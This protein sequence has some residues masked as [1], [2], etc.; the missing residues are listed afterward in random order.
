MKKLLLLPLCIVAM[1]MA[2]CTSVEDNPTP[3]PIVPDEPQPT[4]KADY[5]ILMYGMG[6]GQLIGGGELDQCI[7]CM[8]INQMFE[9]KKNAGD[10]INVVVNYKFSPVLND[11]FYA[12]HNLEG[13][14]EIDNEK[15]SM[16]EFAGKTYRF[17]IEDD[18]TMFDTFVD[19]NLYGKQENDMANPDSLTNFINWAAKNYPAEKY[20]LVL[21]D[22]GG[23]YTVYD[24]LPFNNTRGV[25]YDDTA[26]NHFTVKSLR[27]ALENANERMDVLYYDAC[28]MNSVEYQFEIKH[29]TDYILASTYLVPGEGGL[30]TSL[31][32]KLTENY[33][34]ENALTDYAS[35]LVDYWDKNGNG[36]FIDFSVTKTSELGQYGAI[37]KEFTDHLI[38]AYQSGDPQTKEMIDNVTSRLTFRVDE[39]T[40]GYDIGDYIKMMCDEEY[41]IP[42]KIGPDF[43]GRYLDSYKR[44]VIGTY[45]SAELAEQ[46]YEVD[47]SIILAAKGACA[48]SIIHNGKAEVAIYR[49]DGIMDYYEGSYECDDDEFNLNT[50]L[51][52][53]FYISYNYWNSTFANT[54]EQL[55]FDKEVGWSRWLNINEAFPLQISPTAA[56]E[57]LDDGEDEEGDDYEY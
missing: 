47:Y 3:N 41:G 51:S 48:E 15:L 56:Y 34:L 40:S 26:A 22:H 46:D 6:G 30:Y 45:A 38:I 50:W 36:P 53:D 1:L 44:C 57:D 28:L 21:T 20:V 17:A 54:Y 14:M 4:A 55:E 8:N 19:E 27:H 24:D 18:K 2:S 23:G 7:V 29:L 37:L 39:S 13:G 10:N 12:T 11:D 32:E 35:S 9:G 42:D 52:K 16:S 5:T 31:I 25:L 43:Y 33:D 49:P